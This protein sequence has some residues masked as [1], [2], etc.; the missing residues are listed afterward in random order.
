[1]IQHGPALEPFSNDIIVV[2]AKHIKMNEVFSLGFLRDRPW[3]RY[4]ITAFKV[5][6]VFFANV[7]F[8]G[9]SL[10]MISRMSVI[11]MPEI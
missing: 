3:S 1:M 8:F 11:S 2:I 7:L 10:A 5:A 4:S 6:R 9:G